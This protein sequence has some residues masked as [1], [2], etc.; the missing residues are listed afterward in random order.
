M[1]NQIVSKPKPVISGTAMGTTIRMIESTS[2]TKPAR[3]TKI[4]IKNR[5]PQ[6]PS[7]ITSMTSSA[8][9]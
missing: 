2:M 7:C 9:V 3:K 6:L 8:A 1:K 5:V 4:K